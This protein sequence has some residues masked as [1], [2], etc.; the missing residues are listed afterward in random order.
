[1]EHHSGLGYMQCSSPWVS[2]QPTKEQATIDDPEQ[3]RP[4]LKRYRRPRLTEEE[5]AQIKA[6]LQ[7]GKSPTILA[8][9]FHVERRTISKIRDMKT[10]RHVA[11]A[12]KAR[13]PFR[14]YPR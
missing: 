8:M 9:Y 5:V 10:W 13:P 12:K 4:A 6:H 1:M 14:K 11:A 7:Q 2:D 3:P